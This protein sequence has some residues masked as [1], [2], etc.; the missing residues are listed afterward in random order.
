[1]TPCIE[2]EGP[3]NEGGYGIVGYR[4][5]GKHY[6]DRAHR[7]SFRLAFGFCPDDKMVC[8][9]CDNP[10]CVNPEHLFLGTR[11]DNNA[12][13]VSKGRQVR[14]DTCPASRLTSVQVD[15]IKLLL[16]APSYGYLTRIAK[17]YCVSVVTVHNI[18]TGATWK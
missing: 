16:A 7:V 14:G 17:A 9:K 4:E 11:A 3:R 2:F 8:H 10:P 18:K 6:A 13:K 15:E 1:M 12:D 5:S